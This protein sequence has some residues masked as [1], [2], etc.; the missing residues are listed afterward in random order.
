MIS[1]ELENVIRAW[2]RGGGNRGWVRSQEHCIIGGVTHDFVHAH[3][4][5]TKTETT[6]RTCNSGWERLAAD[7][8]LQLQD[9]ML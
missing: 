6:G 7:V 3:Q 2:P 9:S 4:L 1:G 8:I 5:R